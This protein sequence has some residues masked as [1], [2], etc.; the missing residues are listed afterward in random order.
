ITVNYKR[1][2][3]L[4]LISILIIFLLLP[5]LRRRPSF[6]IERPVLLITVQIQKGI[7]Y[8]SGGV[9]G[10]IERIKNISKIEL[11]N[12]RLQQEVD[13]LMGE[14]RRIQEARQL[15]KQLRE[16]LGFKRGLPYKTLAARIT[17]RDPSNWYKTVMIDRGESDG[18]KKD[19]G[20]IVPSGVVG[21]VIKSGPGFSQVLLITDIESATAV[22]IER[23]RN[24][25]ILEGRGFGTGRVKYIPL[26]SGTRAGDLV[27]TSGLA[28]GLPR[29]LMVGKVNKVVERPSELFQDVE[30]VP[31]VDFNR[32]EEVLVITSLE[33]GQR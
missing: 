33:A 17:G 31:A 2:I 10:T 3:A 26:L 11:E 13:R 6:F 22:L 15:N 14:N 20:V 12:K 4:L 23:T 24:E 32:I 28:G 5:E 7:T 18:V 1:R 21:R 9:V 16:M 8:V 19:M 25:G 29:D 27:L 30:V